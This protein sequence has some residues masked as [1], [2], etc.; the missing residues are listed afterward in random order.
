M[1]EREDGKCQSPVA[2]WRKSCKADWARGTKSGWREAR[3]E[4]GEEVR[5]DRTMQ[6]VLTN[7]DFILNMHSGLSVKCLSL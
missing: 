5:L 4:R 7:L 1:S 2:C 3:S 6:A